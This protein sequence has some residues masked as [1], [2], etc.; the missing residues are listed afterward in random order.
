MRYTLWGVL[1]LALSAAPALAGDVTREDVIKLATA[2]LSDDLIITFL[3]AKGARFDLSAGG[4]VSLKEGGVSEAVIAHMLL[5]NVPAA[6]P[7]S[8]PA[9]KVTKTPA[10]K[11]RSL[12]RLLQGR[13]D[14]TRSYYI[15][16]RGPIYY[17]SR[18][19]YPSYRAY[20]YPRYSHGNCGHH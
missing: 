2:G 14:T 1:I 3:D 17:S 13:Y 12:P 15:P 6:V 4:V 8:N 11:T 20:C 5:S 19:C 10:S 18:Y 7:V 16:V 9:L